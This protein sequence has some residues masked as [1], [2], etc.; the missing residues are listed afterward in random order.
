MQTEI[1]PSE[2]KEK[3]IAFSNAIDDSDLDTAET[4][5][6]ELRAIL[7]DNDSEVVGA[8]VTLDL[9]KI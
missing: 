3:L 7:G 6:K 2:I 8:Q 1:R 5:L 9:E 4:L